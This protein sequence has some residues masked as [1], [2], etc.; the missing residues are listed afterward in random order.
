ML[1]SENPEEFIKF[2]ENRE[3]QEPDLTVKGS[4][5]VQVIKN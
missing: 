4:S 5:R 2:R 1:L 3:A